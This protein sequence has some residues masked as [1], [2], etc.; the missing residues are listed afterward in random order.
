MDLTTLAAAITVA[1]GLMVADV[2]L[3]S[4]KI[5]VD[6][7]VPQSYTEAGV[8]ADIVEALYLSEIQSIIDTPSVVPAPAIRGT[9]EKSLAS[10]LAA[11]LQLAEVGQSL[12]RL[13]GYDPVHVRASLIVEHET[14][15]FIVVES[16]RRG[17]SFQVT[18]EQRPGETV[19]QLIKRGALETMFQL[20]PYLALVHAL[21]TAEGPSDFAKITTAIDG[22][23]GKLPNV[24]I[25]SLRSQYE[26]LRGI[27]ALLNEDVDGAAA[28]FNAAIVSDTHNVVAVLNLSFI[29]CQLDRYA[30]GER[31]VRRILEPTPLTRQ[32]VLLSAAYMGWACTLMGQKDF[33]R[34][35]LVLAQAALSYPQSSSTYQLWSELKEEIGETPEAKQLRRKAR[36]NSIYF[37]NYAEIA[38]LY[39]ELEWRDKQKLRRSKYSNPYIAHPTMSMH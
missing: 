3:S 10:S 18:L 5:I 7:A 31:I 38:T 28:A 26:N 17:R 13:M 32:P 8:T 30:E 27:I 19:I 34:A 11:T 36:E 20:E 23:I 29:A 22:E 16:T 12:Q 35:D 15:K 39:F 4:D 1:L 14:T 24:P 2:A 9:R 21:Q 37:E 33:K 25:S 6:V